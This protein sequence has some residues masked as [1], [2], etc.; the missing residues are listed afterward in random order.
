MN[1]RESKENIRA[2][3]YKADLL[4]VVDSDR[5]FLN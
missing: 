2:S 4:L 5:K 1:A 3:K